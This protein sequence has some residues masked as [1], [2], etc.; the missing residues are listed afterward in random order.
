MLDLL[1][2]KYVGHEKLRL[3]PKEDGG[4]VVPE[5]VLEKSCALFS[6]GISWDD[7]CEHHYSRIL[8]SKASYVGVKR[9]WLHVSLIRKER[10][11]RHDMGGRDYR[12]DL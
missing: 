2:P 9:A 12:A 1:T 11:L 6:Y 3:G 10:C 5:V 4:Y 7:R 8:V